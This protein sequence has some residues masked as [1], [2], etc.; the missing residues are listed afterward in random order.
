MMDP[1]VVGPVSGA[2]IALAGV[3]FATYLQYLSERRQRT[4]K[5]D[6]LFFQALVFLG[7]NPNI[8]LVESV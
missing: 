1:L 5:T 8:K 2:L 4:Q 3:A 7:V 6:E